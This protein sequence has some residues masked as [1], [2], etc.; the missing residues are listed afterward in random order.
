MDLAKA[1]A[2]CS[3]GTAGEIENPRSALP[4]EL[5]EIC[6]KDPLA[7]LGG[8]NRMVTYARDERLHLSYSY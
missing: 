5:T 4:R 8:R 3:T 2:T 7:K 6:M 1:H